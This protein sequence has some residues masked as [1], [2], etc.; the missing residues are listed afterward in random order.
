[1]LF[2]LYCRNNLEDHTVLSHDIVDN[3]R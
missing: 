1:M 3:T 2:S